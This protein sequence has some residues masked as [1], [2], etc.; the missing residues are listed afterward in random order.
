MKFLGVIFDSKLTWNE[1]IRYVITRCSKRINLLRALTGTDWGAN[2]K[3]LIMLYRSLIRSIIDYGSIAYD[4][5]SESSKRLLDQIQSK[6]LRICCG[7]MIMTPVA[8]L[9][10][11][12]GEVPLGLRR[13]ELQLQY[14][15]KLQASPD[16]PTRS[17]MTDCWQNKIKYP[18]EKEPFIV[19]IKNFQQI[20]E[21]TGEII[22]G[23]EYPTQP[24]WITQNIPETNADDG[25]TNETNHARNHIAICGMNDL[26][27]HTTNEN[28]NQLP[29]EDANENTNHATTTNTGGTDPVDIPQQNTE[30]I[31]TKEAKRKITKYI[32]K[33]WQ[34]QWDEST[35]GI[36][37]KK[38]EPLVSRKLRHTQMNRRSENI[39]TRLRFGK[40]DLKF[41][42]NI[43]GKHATGNCSR[44]NVPET[45]EHFILQCSDNLDLVSELNE[46]CTKEG[47]EMEISTVLKHD[48]ILET[49]VNYIIRI[50][51]KI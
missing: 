49:I 14:A 42:L 45:I 32:D 4:S 12:C 46:Q 38:I 26:L 29:N 10:V 15:V 16:N 19:K 44:C 23:N 7:A 37:Y 28:L 30:A 31:T 48:R 51:R 2:K 21:T 40:C 22:T 1:H 24:P 33:I 13:R 50:N 41:Y 11:E 35:K 39:A 5:A 27:N 9:Q 47:I 3:T 8:A 25:A 20:I 36:E 34:R 18:K 17:I 43:I 6:A